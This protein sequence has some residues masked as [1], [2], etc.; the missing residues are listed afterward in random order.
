MADLD[1]ILVRLAHIEERLDKMEA[2]LQEN[3]RTLERY[4]GV[5]GF[6]T[7]ILG[8]LGAVLALFWKNR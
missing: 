2:M 3:T 7:I 8:S 5:V 1:A 6:L 4:R